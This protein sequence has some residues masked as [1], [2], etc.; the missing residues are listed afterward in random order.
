M[1]PIETVDKV[2]NNIKIIASVPTSQN[3]FT[4]EYIRYL[5]SRETELKVYPALVRQNQEYISKTVTIQTDSSGV[6]DIPS[7]A[8][9][10]T[11]MSVV[12][13]TVALT[14]VDRERLNQSPNGYLFQGNS[15]KTNYTNSSLEITYVPSGREYVETTAQ[16]IITLINN[17]LKRITLNANFVGNT[18][19]IMTEQGVLVRE[20]IVKVGGTGNQVVLESV[21]GLTVNDI[22]LVPYTTPFVNY[23]TMAVRYLERCVANCLLEEMQDV[24]MLQVG[25]NSEASMLKILLDSLSSRGTKSA[26]IPQKRRF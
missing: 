14:S 18:L 7:D 21:D 23:P 4:D 16:P 6:F 2:L 24:E 19:D 1:K 8:F 17:T 3:R 13:N 22:V 15:I 9:V 12:H 10:S 25:Q 20:N 11:V 5:M 26:V